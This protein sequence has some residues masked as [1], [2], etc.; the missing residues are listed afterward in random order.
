MSVEDPV[1][2]NIIIRVPYTPTA[3]QLHLRVSSLMAYIVG[4]YLS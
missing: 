3:L 4:A 1:P 2:D